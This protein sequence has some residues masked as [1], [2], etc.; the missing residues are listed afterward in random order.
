MENK[1]QKSCL[2]KNDFDEL[3]RNDPDQLYTLINNLLEISAK[4]EPLTEKVI[5][6]ENRIKELENQL[7]KNSHNSSKPPSSDGLKKKPKPQSLRKKSNKKSGGQNGHQG[8]T[9]EM[10]ETPDKITNIPLNICPCCGELLGETQVEDHKKR[11]VFDIP[12]MPI[13]V[14]EYQAET[15]TCGHCHSKVT[16]E[17]PENITSS[18]QYGSNLKSYIIYLRNQNFIPTDRLATLL[19]DLFSVHISE[20]T[21]Y[22][23]LEAFSK[24]VRPFDEWVKR[25]LFQSKLFHSD[26]TGARIEGKL[27]WLHSASNQYYT[28]YFPHKKRGKEAMDEMNILPAYTG[29]VIHDYWKSYLNY[30]SC[31]HGLCNAHH[32]REL[33]YLFDVEKQEWADKMF[34]HLLRIKEEVD[35]AEL[36]GELIDKS[37]SDALLK[38]YDKILI[39][40]FKVNPM[41]VKIKGKRGRPKK[42]KSLCLLERFRDGKDKVLAFMTD[43]LVPFD[44]NLAERDIRMAKLYQKISGCFRTMKGAEQFFLTRGFLSTARKQN[45]NLIDSISKIFQG[46]SIT[47]IFG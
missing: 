20:G 5:W 3:L 27:H 17:F 33:T 47:E 30:T 37:K 26:E 46:Q 38:I 19:E 14:E 44:N 28:C 6:Q 13:F 32:L 2:T 10:S 9:L 12:K 11:Q 7:K 1:K 41:P 34:K 8:K 4:V 42:G 21:I 25:K 29:Y 36:K 18:V 45:L 35:K 24:K 23:T 16:A 43:I 31:K 22:N 39:D 15:K 40:G